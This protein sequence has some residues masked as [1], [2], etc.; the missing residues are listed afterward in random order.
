[1]RS[2]R[3]AFY[4]SVAVA[5][6]V[7]ARVEEARRAREPIDH[8][9]FVP[10]GE[11]TLDVGLGPAIR[12]LRPLGI[13]VAVITNGSLLS[14]PDVRAAV[15]EAARVSVKIDT[16]REET[17]RRLNRPHRRLELAPILEGIQDF[18]SAFTGVLTTETMLV[19][20]V[21]DTPD[22]LRATADF[23]AL[24]HPR[25]AYLSVPTRP[26][27]AAWARPP[28]EATVAGAYEIFAA[29]HPWVETLLGYEGDA[30]S[31]TGDPVDDL[32][33]ITAVHPMREAAVR[34]MLAQRGVP[35]ATVQDLVEAGRLVPVRHG[36]HRYFVRSPTPE[37]WSAR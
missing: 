23:V 27:A 1:M 10:D 25:T 37:P 5:T 3:Q 8:L 6:E 26:P 20:D 14:R 13:P 21:N 19:A 35:W 18:A 32:L 7:R 4:G 28:D 36:G 31:S 9:T 30:F 17:W 34:R 12:L 2:E 11:P 16:V 24:L 15:A 33:S 22:E 29:R